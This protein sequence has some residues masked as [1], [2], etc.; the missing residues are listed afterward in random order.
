MLAELSGHRN[1]K[2]ITRP[3]QIWVEW[4]CQGEAICI[5]LVSRR[6]RWVVC[7]CGA[8]HLFASRFC[9]AL[10]A[11]HVQSQNFHKPHTPKPCIVSPL[12]RRND[13]CG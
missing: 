7:F 13:A 6:S 1:T 9:F 12:L 5:V 10:F 2:V 8:L 3:W 4:L 11:F